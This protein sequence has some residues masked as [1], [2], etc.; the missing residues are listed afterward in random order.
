M[1]KGKLALVTGASSGMGACF[2]RQLAARGSDLVITAR[3]EDRLKALAAE[4]TSEH[5]VSVTILPLDISK[6]DAPRV[7]FSKTEEA[8]RP[9]DVLVNNAGFANIGLFL[10][11]AWERTSE[12]L[13]VNMRALTELCWLFGRPMF[14]RKSGYILNVASFASF[15]PVPNMAAYAASKAYVRNLSEALAI[16]L[17]G[18]GVNVCALCPG[19]VATD[20]FEVAGRAVDRTAIPS[21]A[22]GPEKIAAAGLSALFAGKHVCLPVAKDHVNAFFMRLL[23]RGFVMRMAGK[24]M[25]LPKNK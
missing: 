16:E 1:L 10:D 15:T 23:P 20:F 13:D 11:T 5:G 7:L 6:P 19:P 17:E 4:I 12:L 18:Q 21:G 25:G 8:G 2:A 14:A 3:R 9:V 24:E 22:A